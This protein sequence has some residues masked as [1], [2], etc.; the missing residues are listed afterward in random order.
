MK[1]RYVRPEASR[2]LMNRAISEK[3]FQQQIIDLARLNGYL[4]YHTWN[5]RHSAAGFPDLVLCHPVTGK[6]IFA[7]IK[8]E[9]NF[10][11]SSQLD[12]LRALASSG[13]RVFVWRPGDWDNIVEVLT[14]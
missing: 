9:G 3:D 7:E 1:T 5:S 11:S 13:Q 2:Q 12:W 4:V 10:A 14:K 6:L 8:T